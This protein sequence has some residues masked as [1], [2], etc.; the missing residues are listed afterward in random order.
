[1]KLLCP[2]IMCADFS[3]LQEEISALEEANV[4]M[5]HCD[6]MDGVF[7][8]N[9]T[10]GLNDVK[11]IR[12]LTKKVVDCH[13]MIENPLSKIDLFIDAGADLLYVHPESERYISKTLMHIKNRGKL[14]GLAI[15][16]DT[17]IESIKEVIG[18]ADYILVMTVNPGFA[19][20][21]FLDFTKEKIKKLNELKNQYSYKIIADGACS[22]AV[23]QELD[24]LGCD[25]YV[26]GTSALFGKNRSYKQL[27]EELQ[28]L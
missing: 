19:G 22:P 12:G 9:F 2:S 16:P 26:L 1:M 18:L 11:A 24:N 20:Q 27:I 6:I 15:N 14:S 25:G 5:Y 4:T 10:M 8:P 3:S 28:I 17:S 13:L 7:V 23:I 21:A